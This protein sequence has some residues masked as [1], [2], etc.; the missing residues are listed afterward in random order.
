[1]ILFYTKCISNVLCIE[2]SDGE[3]VCQGTDDIWRHKHFHG[4]LTIRSLKRQRACSSAD[5]HHLAG[6][7]QT[8]DSYLYL[9]LLLF[10]QQT[11]ILIHFA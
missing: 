4:E 5:D 1:M 11:S 10:Y 3:G 9:A 6:P 7:S 2:S 8:V